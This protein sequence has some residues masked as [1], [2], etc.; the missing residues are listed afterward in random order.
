MSAPVSDPQAETSEL[1]LLLC[2][3]TSAAVE[4]GAIH[5]RMRSSSTA[6]NRARLSR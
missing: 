4:R 1:C 2:A 6:M 5:S 3:W